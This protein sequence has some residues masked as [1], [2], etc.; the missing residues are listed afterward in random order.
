MRG[1]TLAVTIVVV[2]LLGTGAAFAGPIITNGSFEAVQIGSPFFSA[3]PADIPGW[4]HGSSPGD[5]LLW[6]VGYADGNGS[7]TTAGAGNQFV[8]VGGGFDGSGTANRSPRIAAWTPP[9]TSVLSFMIATE[10]GPGIE[11]GGPRP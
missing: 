6:A 8:P 7:R 10:L 9:D 11:P 1:Q 5:A 2:S 4:T 3:N